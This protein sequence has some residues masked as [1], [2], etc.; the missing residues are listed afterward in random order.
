MWVIVIVVVKPPAKLPEH[1]AGV[2]QGIK[3]RI[4][5]LEGTNEGLRWWQ[6]CQSLV[7]PSLEWSQRIKMAALNRLY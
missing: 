6:R 1:G 7:L 2:G 3:A 5:A 4:V